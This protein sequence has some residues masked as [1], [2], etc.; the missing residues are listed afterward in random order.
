MV[1]RRVKYVEQMEQSECGLACL[2]M[3]LNYHHQD[4]NLASLRD[5]YG[6][7]KEGMTFQHLYRLASEKG[8]KAN[9]YQ[10]SANELNNKLTPSIIHWEDKHFVVLEKVN[11]HSYIIVDPAEGRKKISLAEF[12]E[13]YTG[14]AMYMANPSVVTPKKENKIGILARLVINHRKLI[15]TIFLVTI[16]M[17]LFAIVTP[18]GTKWFTDS[19]LRQSFDFNGVTIGLLLVFLFSSYLLV[20]LLRNWMISKLQRVLDKDLMTLFMKRLFH[21]PIQFFENRAS[22]DLLFRAN[23]NNYIRQILSTTSVSVFVDILMVFTYLVIMFKY[24]VQLSIYLMFFTLGIVLI[25]F[26]HTKVLKK[27][28]DQYVGSQTKVQSMVS[29]SINSVLDIKIFGLEKNLLRE[30]N[31]LFSNQLSNGYKLSIWNGFIQSITSSLQYIIPLFIYGIGSFYVINNQITIGT[32]VAFG[33]IA[34]TFIT[35]IISL[36][37]SYTQLFTVRAYVRRILDVIDSNSE[38]SIDNQNLAESINGSLELSNVS[39]SYSKYGKSVLK[40]INILIK[41]GET[42]AIVG[43]SGSGKS[44]LLKLILG[45]YYATEGEVKFNGKNIIDYD[46]PLLRSQIGSVLQES[47]LLNRTIRENLALFDDN[48]TDEQLFSACYKANILKDIMELPMNFNTI[49]SEQGANFSGGQRQR[50]QIARALIKSR[51]ILVLDEATSALDTISEQ[52]IQK[53]V[54]EVSCTKIIVAHRLS[55]IQ[56]ADKI[57]VLAKGQIVEQGT[58]Q[59]LLNKKGEYYRIYEKVV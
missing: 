49:V 34:T 38:H 9:A 1:K 52:I 42:V 54:N 4:V 11:M 46:L 7:T 47:T 59:Q 24:S 45:L 12:K 26:M 20:N 5:E 41:P 37:S 39:C 13:K 17:Q 57:F 30:W 23:S 44:T 25:M 33:T 53:H 19:L 14:F 50:L 35:P 3:L 22:G 21:L 31:N 8:L 15:F 32:L 55:T 16:I 58:H 43:E 51:P 48:I 27:L 40:N 10:V 36:S 2:S 18:V 6:S 56:Q 28:N 29:E